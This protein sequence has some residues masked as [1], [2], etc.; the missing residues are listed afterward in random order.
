MY[1]NIK[2]YFSSDTEVNITE[3]NIPLKASF[4]VTSV[5]ES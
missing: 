2:Y 1:A 3:I 4:I 5:T